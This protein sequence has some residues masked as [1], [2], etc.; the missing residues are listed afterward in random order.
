MIFRGWLQVI[1]VCVSLIPSCAF[2]Q[3]TPPLSTNASSDTEVMAQLTALRDAFVEQ[4]KSEGFQP[5]LPPPEIILGN[6]PPYG[7]YDDDKNV[8]VIAAWAALTPGQQSQFA[9]MARQGETGQQAFDEEVYHWVLIHELGHWWQKCEYKLS[10]DRYYR[11]YGANRIAAAYWRLK[12]PEI[13]KM[14]AQRTASFFA[15]MPNPVPAGQ[16]KE[17]YFD[18]NYEKLLPTPAYDWFQ[19][20]MVLH[21]LAAEKSL[22]SLRHC[23]QEPT[24]AP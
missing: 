12:D 19:A 1:S 17:T 4:I 2:A 3:T 11:E 13:L 16:Q 5:S 18:E 10:G 20:D 23:L 8:L 22:P 21:L 14:T 15:A 24:V 9:G 7:T 6:P